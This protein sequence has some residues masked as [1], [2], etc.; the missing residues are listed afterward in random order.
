[1]VNW[2]R[3]TAEGYYDQ[4]ISIPDRSSEELR[5]FRQDLINKS[6]ELV[7]FL[8]PIGLVLVW[9]SYLYD[10]LYV[11]EPYL[12]ALFQLMI[13]LS[14][15]ILIATIMS[16][17]EILLS[18]FNLVFA[19]LFAPTVLI[20]V[21]YLS[22][23]GREFPPI[24]VIAFLI[25]FVTII[26]PC[27]FSVRLTI[28]SISFLIL[29]SF[30][31]ERG[32]SKRFFLPASGVVF[33]NVLISTLL[34]HVYFYR[35]NF[36]NYFARNDLEEARKNIE[37]E[38]E[39]SEQLLTNVLPRD[40]SKRLKKGEEVAERFDQASVLFADIEKFTP[41]ASHLPASDVVGLLDDIFKSFDEL[42]E[43]RDLEKIKTIGDE[44]FVTAGVPEPTDDHAVKL[45]K[46]A[47]R[48]QSVVRDYTHIDGE[49]I[50][51]RIGMNTGPVTAGVIGKVRFVYDLWGDT[52]NVGSRMESLGKP[53][54][55]QVTPATK[56]AIEEQDEDGL[57]EFDERGTIQVKGK[58]EMI[59]YFL[60]RNGTKVDSKTC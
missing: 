55:V 59:T 27:G 51:L 50:Q 25:P 28:T 53:G 5:A 38:R 52:V 16:Y 8:L 48:I 41:L 54:K 58:G 43:E 33:L 23:I 47:F 46:F 13:V 36:L 9:L 14:I 24:L 15:P 10:F 2:I 22:Y 26:L 32:W 6:N 19:V 1:M 12:S 11:R 49:P 34:G 29:V 57:F 3:D 39:K 31:L 37:L 42:S 30:Y 35:L 40:I 7:R 56:Q 44:Y 20:A 18:Y 4:Y 45:A 60:S 17:A 21:Y